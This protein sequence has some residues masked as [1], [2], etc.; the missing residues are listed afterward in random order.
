MDNGMV[1]CKGEQV[2]S[3]DIGKKIEEFIKGTVVEVY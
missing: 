2:R 1:W 3:D